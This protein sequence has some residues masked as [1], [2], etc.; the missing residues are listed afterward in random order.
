[1][2]SAVLTAKQSI[3][4]INQTTGPLSAT[5]VKVRIHAGGIC[6]SDL[7][8]FHHYRM[9]D[10]PVLE[11]FILGH[12]AAGIVEEIGSTVSNIA[13]GDKVV[14][15]PSHPCRNCEYCLK[16]RELLCNDM[17]FLGSSRKF[18]HIQGMFSE[19]FIADQRQCFKVPN[20]LS[21]NVAAFAE[22]LAVALHAINQ[23]GSLLGAEV[24]ISGSGPIGALVLL[25]AKLAGAKSITMTDIRDAPLSV[26]SELGADKTFNVNSG[27]SALIDEDNPRGSFDVAF[28]ASGSLQAVLAAINNIRPGGSLIQIGTFA[29]PN[30]SL[31]S[32]QLMV[33]EIIMKSSFRFDKEFAWAVDYLA[34]NKIDVMPLLTHTFPMEDANKAFRTASD[35]ENAMKVQLTF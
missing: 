16:G 4:T 17:K 1:M 31:P 24:L 26:V 14:I 15:N 6:G 11:P 9:G 27:A 13:V 3:K 23:A 7:H 25:A 2:R 21:L 34:K 8:Y 10:F 5:E 12:E 30:I 20:E 28:D 33:K 22:P 32:D 29:E 35:R 18:P 19:I